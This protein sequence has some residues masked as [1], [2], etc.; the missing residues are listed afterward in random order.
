MRDLH[1]LDAELA[2]KADLKYDLNQETEACAWLEALIG[3]SIIKDGRSFIESLRSG[4]IL[5]KAILAISPGVFERP[6]NQ[7]PKHYLEEQGNISMYLQACTK[8]GIPSQDLFT[9]IDIGTTKPDKS[10]V[11]QNIYAL[12]RQAQAMRVPVPK[13]GVTFHK[14]LEDIARL[15]EKKRFDRQKDAEKRKEYDER[16]LRRRLQLETEKEKENKFKIQST[17]E[18]IDNRKQSRLSRGRE[19]TPLSPRREKEEKERSISPVKY[20]MD[21]EHSKMMASKEDMSLAEDAIMD[22][23][24]DITKE[25]IDDLFLHLKSGR[26]LCRLLNKLNVGISI[27]FSKGSS[28]VHEMNNIKLFLDSLSYF[29]IKRDETFDIQDLYSKRNMNL[30]IKTLILISSKLQSDSKYTGPILDFVE[31]PRQVCNDPNLS[32]HLKRREKEKLEKAQKEQLLKPESKEKI[33]KEDDNDSNIL[34]PSLFSW[35]RTLGFTFVGI[36]IIACYYFRSHISQFIQEISSHN[37]VEKL[38][39]IYT[40]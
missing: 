2:E 33:G 35:Y 24:E 17:K 15:E 25:P 39:L 40:E 26:T 5:C 28:A 29:N 9:I 14:S 10:I 20:G 16:A 30:V 4:V 36:G 1:G 21:L 6:Y 12:G 23:I 37:F 13:L 22:W 38:K 27:K 3:E 31:Q 18:K 32:D 11:L 8:I 19:L 34:K 7:K